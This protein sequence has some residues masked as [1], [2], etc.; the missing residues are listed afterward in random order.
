MSKSVSAP[1]LYFVLKTSR[2]IY[3]YKYTVSTVH[4]LLLL[5]LYI[6]IYTTKHRILL[7]D[8]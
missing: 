4:G 2:Y 8:L 1:D 6:Y 7:I 5:L 3:I